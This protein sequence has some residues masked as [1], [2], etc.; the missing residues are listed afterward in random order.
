MTSYRRGQVVLVVFPDSNLVT[1][2]KRPALVVQDESVP[3]GLSQHIVAMITSNMARTGPTRVVVTKNSV[4]GRRMGLLTDS[5][6]ATDN[7]ATILDREV[8]KVLGECRD[9]KAMDQALRVTLG[10]RR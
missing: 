1:F 6:V 7:L 2:K 10:L 9:M 4:T 8:A 3:T 5:V